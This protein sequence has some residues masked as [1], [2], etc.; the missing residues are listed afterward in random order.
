[1]NQ[2]DAQHSKQDGIVLPLPPEMRAQADDVALYARFMQHLRHVPTSRM[3]IKIL[4][5]IQFSA[6]M[7]CHSDAHVAKVLVDFGL[8]AP[9]VAFPA[10]FLKFADCSLQRSSWDIGGPN[11][12]L[13][14]L[15]AYWDSIGESKFS[16]LRGEYTLMSEGVF[17]F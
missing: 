3:E 13:Q 17:C 6:D 12:A 15:R 1:M 7:L 9:R 5:A 10:D 11:E 2:H 4:S 8:R 14:E 16:Y